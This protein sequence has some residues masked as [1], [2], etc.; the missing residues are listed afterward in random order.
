MPVPAASA[1]V[2]AL[3]TD[4]V[5]APHDTDLAP[6]VGA[7]SAAGVDGRVVEWDD[8]EVD[9]DG[10]DLT[11]IRSTWSYT[12]RLDAYLTR[13]AHVAARTVLVNPLA[14]V[15]ATVDKGYL[16]S[17]AAADVPVVPTEV[18]R[19]GEQVTVPRGVE[20]VVKPTVSAGARDTGR[21][22]PDQ[23]D[24]AEAHARSLLD[25]GRGV[26]VQPYLAAVDSAGETGLVFIGDRFSHGFRKEPLLHPHAPPV[27]GP[28]DAPITSR[29]PSAAERDVAEAALDAVAGLA[30]GLGR[31]DLLYARVDLV[32]GDDGPVLME[33]ELIEPSL[34]LHVDPAS[35]ARTAAAIVD[36]LRT[37]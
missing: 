4:A 20:V 1:P 18:V 11:V 24:E 28:R 6:L 31:G 32:P 36:R 22:G 35:P 34:Y 26:L 27:G 25:R 33:L 23:R 3:L 13:L 37:G 2:V 30:P 19:P 21:Y 12:D 8:G 10:I 14:V 29:E 5:S 9:W 17:L 7:L 15:E 16:R